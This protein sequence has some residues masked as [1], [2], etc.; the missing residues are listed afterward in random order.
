M[1]TFLSLF[2]SLCGFLRNDFVNLSYGPEIRFNFVSTE[3]S[4]RSVFFFLST[5]LLLC[6]P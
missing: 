3:F 6:L 5:S 2:S 4:S 1:K